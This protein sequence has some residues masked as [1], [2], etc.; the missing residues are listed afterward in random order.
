MLRKTGWLWCLVLALGLSL[1]TPSAWAAIPQPK[2]VFIMPIEF[3]INTLDPSKALAW[4][5]RNV[6]ANIFMALAGPSG[7]D[8]KTMPWLAE[9][10][11]TVNPSTWKFTIRPNIHFQDGSLMTSA[12]VKFSFDRLLGR[13]D[14]RFPGFAK[15]MYGDLIDTMETPDDRTIVFTTK[16]VEPLFP[17]VISAVFMVPKAYIEKV[18][19]KEFANH[20]VGQGPYKFVERKRGESITLEAFENY[21]NTQPKRGELGYS[22]VKTVIFRIIPEMQTRIAALQAGEVSCMLGVSNDSAKAL[23]KDSKIQLYYMPINSPQLIMF[24]WLSD[25]DPATGKPNP[26]LDVRVRQA[27]NYALD[28]DAIMKNYL[29]G[30]EYRTT[31]V[32]KGSAGYNPDVPFYNYNPEKA[33]A[34]LKEAGYPDGIE[35]PFHVPTDVRPSTQALA[36]YWR[37]AGIRVKLKHTTQA[38]VMTQVYRKELY[39]L[40]HWNYGRGAETSKGFFD[41]M[42]KHDGMYA[43]HARDE[44]IDKM[45]QEWDGEF[46]SAKRTTLSNQIVNI[47]WK[48]AWYVPLW[49]PVVISALRKEWNYEY[50]PAVPGLWLPNISQKQ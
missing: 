5:S 32:G 33:K 9:S 2:G 15:K 46:D 36:Q 3:D 49:E 26:F 16:Y 8:W 23:E 37:D 31:L 41:T 7:E 22:K 10:W 30:R 14:R 35:V 12:D 27:L 43:L 18:G 29:T 42:L 34:L 28:L 48:D 11:E 20:P 19:D 13:L 24:N 47:V 38:V 45:V 21:F 4:T 44:R 1:A 25:K 40:V 6:W 17:Y 39:G 50:L